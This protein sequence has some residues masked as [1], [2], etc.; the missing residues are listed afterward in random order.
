MCRIENENRLYVVGRWYMT[1]FEVEYVG[2]GKGR[3]D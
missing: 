3:V 1:M 2:Y